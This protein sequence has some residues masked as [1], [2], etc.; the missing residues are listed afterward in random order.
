MRRVV[1]GYKLYLPHARAIVARE[2]AANFVGCWG[3][4]SEALAIKFLSLGSHASYRQYLSILLDALLELAKQ[5]T[6]S[7]GGCVSRGNARTQQRLELSRAYLQHS[8]A[9]RRNL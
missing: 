3:N 5:N 1:K 4:I 9:S 6:E 8:R 7:L 2:A